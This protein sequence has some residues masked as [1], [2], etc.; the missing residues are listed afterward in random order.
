LMKPKWNSD[1]VSGDLLFAI[2]RY[3][4]VH[5]YDGFPWFINLA[6][7]EQELV[8]V[9]N[10]FKSAVKTMQEMGLFPSENKSGN[11]NISLDPKIFDQKGAP[12]V[13]ARLGRD[14]K[15]NPAWFVED[16]EKTG[17]YYK[18]KG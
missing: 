2:L 6:H 15:G 13:G 18:L 14:E 4:G 16:P 7:T 5:V 17:E 12:M 10:A 1:I 3:N 11:G 9:L 8:E